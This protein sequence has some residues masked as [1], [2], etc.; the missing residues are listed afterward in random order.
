M[1]RFW[2]AAAGSTDDETATVQRLF[3]LCGGCRFLMPSDPFEVVVGVERRHAILALVRALP[4]LIF[5]ARRALRR[6][7]AVTLSAN[8]GRNAASS[9]AESAPATAAMSWPRKK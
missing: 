1:A 3:L 5:D 4:L 2:L 7:T 8:L 9:I 6:C